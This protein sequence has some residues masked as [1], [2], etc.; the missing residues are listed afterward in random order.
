M[1]I[2]L[3]TE[4]EYTL[5]LLYDREERHSGGIHWQGHSSEIKGVQGQVS[6]PVKSPQENGGGEAEEE[7]DVRVGRARP[8]VI[9]L[10]MRKKDWALSCYTTDAN[11]DQT[12]TRASREQL[13]MSKGK[14]EK[15]QDAIV[16]RGRAGRYKRRQRE[17][18]N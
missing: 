13:S 16:P 18:S 9:E 10:V 14:N 12:M 8:R 6:I 3:P 15:E 17:E 7:G 1:K 11:T 2:S 4:P 5:A